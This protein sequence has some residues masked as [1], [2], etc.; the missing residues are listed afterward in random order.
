MVLLGVVKIPFLKTF[1]DVQRGQ[2]SNEDDWQ[3]RYKSR[4]L[5]I[6]LCLRL[7]AYYPILISSSTIKSKSIEYDSF[8][9]RS[10]YSMILSVEISP[11]EL[12]T[13]PFSKKLDKHI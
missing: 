10:I 9:L 7:Q 13:L 8:K 4:L 11:T 2:L 6:P 5:H 12:Q 3:S 1:V